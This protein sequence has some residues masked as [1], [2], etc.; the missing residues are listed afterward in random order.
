LRPLEQCPHQDER[1]E[2]PEGNP[3]K[4]VSFG[5]LHGPPPAADRVEDVRDPAAGRD[6]LDLD[7]RHPRVQDVVLN[8]G[9]R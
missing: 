5:Y 7:G 9:Y 2:A 3:L 4:L 8:T 1:T 6:I